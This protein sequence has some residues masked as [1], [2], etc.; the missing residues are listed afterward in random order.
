MQ[1]LRFRTI[2]CICK[3]SGLMRH[4]NKKLQSEFKNRQEKLLFPIALPFA[5]DVVAGG[6]EVVLDVAGVV[7]IPDF[8][9]HFDADAAK[10]GEQHCSAGENL[11]DVGRGCGDLLL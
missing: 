1:F 11:D 10:R 3:I 2:V 5:F 6:F 8:E 7:V 4:L 9:Q